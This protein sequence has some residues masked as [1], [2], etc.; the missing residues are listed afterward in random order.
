ME[1]S[2]PALM[3]RPAPQSRVQSM[4]HCWFGNP[5]AKEINNHTLII[6]A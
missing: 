1:W 5:A 2:P 6:E 4:R 3:G